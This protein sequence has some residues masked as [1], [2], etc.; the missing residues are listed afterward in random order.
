M[1]RVIVECHRECE[2]GLLAPYINLTKAFDT[3]HC[4][5]LW[6]ILRLRRIPTRIIGLIANLY[7][8]TGSV[9][10]AVHDSRLSHQEISSHLDFCKDVIA[11]LLTES[12]IRRTV[13]V[14]DK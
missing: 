13:R 10:N 8:G 9:V 6:E 5:S 7:T 2:R 12:N 14:A 3:V 4:E 11:S 1:L